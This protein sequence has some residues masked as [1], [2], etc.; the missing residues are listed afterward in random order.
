MRRKETIIHCDACGK[1]VTEGDIAET[2]TD[3]AGQSHDLCADCHEA[4]WRLR[5]GPGRIFLM[6]ITDP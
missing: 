4:G 3:P 5:A 1:R 2:Q 6:Y